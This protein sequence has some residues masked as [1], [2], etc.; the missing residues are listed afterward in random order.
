[1]QTNDSLAY[2]VAPGARL[3]LVRSHTPDFRLRDLIEGFL[4]AAKRPDVDVLSDSSGI[5]MVPDTAADFVGLLLD[6]IVAAY[7]KPIFHA[8]GIM[9][10]FL[11]SVSSLGAAFSVG[12]S[13]GP[14][15]FA[16]LFGGAPLP[17]LM[18]HPIGAAGPGLDGAVKPDFVAPVHRIAADLSAGP[19]TVAIPKNAPAFSLPAGY[20]IS[21]CT[22]SSTPY[23][24]GVAALILSAAK[25]EHVAHP[26]LSFARALRLGARFL[27]ASPSFDQGNGVLDVNRAWNE[28]RRS[29]AIPR[30]VSQANIVH[31][32]AAYAARRDGQGIFERDGWRAPMSGT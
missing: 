18:V 30:I 6:R 23:A 20:Q 13:V 10:L 28:L 3:L 31:P 7:G 21:C 17:G 19:A 26:Y 15:T 24:A 4:I 2:G 12:G 25:Q 16:A 29:I 22:S 9:S 27:P 32:L 14:D 8:A 5:L 11:G 1:S